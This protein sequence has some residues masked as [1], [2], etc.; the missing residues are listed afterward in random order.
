M[1]TKA[2]THNILGSLSNFVFL[3]LTGILLLPY[4]FKFISTSEYG[5]WLGGISFLSLVSVFE[6]NISLI[7]T[8]QLG[9][10]WVNKK[11]DEFS[12]YF[13]AAIIFGLLVSIVVVFV[14]YFFKDMLTH[15]VTPS[16]AVNKSY[17][18]SFFLYS[19]ALSLTIISGYLNSIPQVFLKT[20]WPPIFNLISSVFGIV[21]TLWAIPHQGILAL[22][23]GNLVKTLIYTILDF[24]YVLIILKKEQIPFCV[25]VHYLFM[26]IKNI[27]LPF[28]SKVG[29]TLA[30]SIQNFIVATTIS[31][32]ATTIFEITKKLPSLTVMIINMIAVSTFTSFSLFYSESDNKGFVHDYTKHY[33]SLIRMMLVFTLLIIFLIGQDFISIWVGLDKFG[34]NYLLSLICL[35]VFSDQ[36]RMILSQQYYAIGKFNLT[37]ITD[38]VFA[39]SFLVF[40]LIIM[41]IIGLEGIVIAGIG[42][43]LIYFISCAILEKRFHTDMVQYIITKNLLLDLSV[44]FLISGSAILILNQY[45]NSFFVLIITIALAALLMAMFYYKREVVLL[46]F[47]ISKFVRFPKK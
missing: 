15:W 41:P 46:K 11:L 37:S 35:T 18:Q 12:K 10:K 14:T 8:Q 45:R 3:F 36:L 17:S 20:F 31:S 44:V 4:Y 1:K 7:L 40:A 5:I 22:A 34:G 13:S 39:V 24:F 19:I 38:S 43:N 29:M 9:N 2:I 28:I 25:D 23:S 6:A 47:I 30:M 26:L 42:A 27:G 21:Y 32:S 33:F 16:G